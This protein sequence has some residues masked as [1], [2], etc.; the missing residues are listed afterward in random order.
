MPQHSSKV[1]NNSAVSP[2]WF[3]GSLAAPIETQG[4]KATLVSKTWS[5]REERLVNRIKKKW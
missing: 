2:A 5:A 3:Y 1:K 4:V